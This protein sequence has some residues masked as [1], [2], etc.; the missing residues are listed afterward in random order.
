MATKQ[1]AKKPV[2]KTQP[3][4][5]NPK[6]SSSKG[7][8]AKQVAPPPQGMNPQLKALLL[9][10]TSVL[11]FALLIIKGGNLWF[12]FRQCM[13]GLFGFCFLL[14][15][16]VFLYM[17][18]MTAKEKQ[19]SHKGLKVSF[20]IA[21]VMLTCTLIYL[22][23]SIDYNEKRTYIQALADALDSIRL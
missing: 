16:F 1:T 19:M 17:G 15:P 3:N 2:K 5:S 11:F 22:C 21:I 13:I 12:S 8:G 10:A 20:S 6:G 7:R 9:V 23:G 4:K 18:I 14:I